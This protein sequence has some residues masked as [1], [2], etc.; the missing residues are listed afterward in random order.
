MKSTKKALD[1]SEI[2]GAII[3]GFEKI[4]IKAHGSSDAHAF[5]NALRQ[6]KEMNELSILSIVEKN[7]R[8]IK[9]QQNEGTS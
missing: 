1:A 7:M 5:K 9:E 8:S 6:A 3:M 4:V 2:G